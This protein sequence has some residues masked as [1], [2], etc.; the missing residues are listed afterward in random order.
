MSTVLIDMVV[1]VVTLGLF[2]WD[3]ASASARAATTNV[4]GP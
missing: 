3:G 4:V 2:A 1:L